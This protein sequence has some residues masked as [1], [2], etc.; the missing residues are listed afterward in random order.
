MI[1]D[2]D[3]IELLKEYESY[4]YDLYNEDDFNNGWWNNCNYEIIDY[5]K[6]PK[7]N[8]INFLIE[9]RF[10]YPKKFCRAFTK[11]N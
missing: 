10:D 1:L 7:G 4:I 2:T 11:E 9:Y 5:N 3:S 8:T 6:I